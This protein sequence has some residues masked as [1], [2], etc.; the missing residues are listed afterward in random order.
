M[1]KNEIYNYIELKAQNIYVVYIKDEDYTQ[2]ASNKK[3]WEMSLDEAWE[4]F[5][6]EVMN[7]G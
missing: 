5:K 3:L 7:N 4:D 2:Y 6:D 1:N